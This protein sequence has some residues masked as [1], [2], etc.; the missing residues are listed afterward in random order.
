VKVHFD[1]STQIATRSLIEADTAT[2]R[3][4]AK[5][6]AGKRVTAARDDASSLAIGMRLKA[7]IAGLHQASTNIGQAVST[8]QVADGALSRISD[9]LLRMKSLGVQASSAQLSTAER[10][11]LN[12]EFISLRSEIDR[13]AADT[14]FSGTQLLNGGAAIQTA[15][16]ATNVGASIDLN[17]GFVGFLFANDANNVSD[18]DVFRIRYQLIGGGATGR[19]RVQN[20]TTAAQET[21]DTPMAS[22]G[23]ALDIT[24]PFFDLTISLN[25]SFDNNANQNG[26]PFEDYEFIVSASQ[27]GGPLQITY[28]VGTGVNSDDE[29][30]VTLEGAGAE[31]LDSRLESASLVS[32]SFANTAI[33]AVDAAIDKTA[34]MRAS[35]GAGLNRLEFAAA[36]LATI[37]ENTEIARSTLLDLDVASEMSRFIQASLR[38]DVVATMMSQAFG[39]KR[40]LLQIIDQSAHSPNPKQNQPS[41]LRHLK[42]NLE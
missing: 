36:N 42:A 31:A 33:T 10:A 41:N 25:A 35:L 20:T 37:T 5:L 2:T 9:I 24:V 18:G 7:Q 40:N 22:F 16:T 6:S 4:L 38:S 30:S 15:Y 12:R 8:L 19:F 39:L 11:F 1:L 21:I 32:Q 28:K 23:S 29:I 13:I 3:A 26:P 14:T 17:D 34:E 27:T